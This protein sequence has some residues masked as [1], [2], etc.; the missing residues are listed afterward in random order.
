MNYDGSRF[1]HEEALREIHRVLVPGGVFGMI[2]NVEDCAHPWVLH[3]SFVAANCLV[4]KTTLLNPGSRTHAGS[5]R[6]K[7]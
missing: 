3:H 5:R 4:F 7:I 2:W 6:S 1:A